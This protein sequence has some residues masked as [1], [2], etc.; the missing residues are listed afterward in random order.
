MDSESLGDRK[1]QPVS[2]TDGLR[3][4]PHVRKRSNASPRASYIGA[5]TLRLRWVKFRE[6]KSPSKECR[7]RD[8]L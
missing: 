2:G 1:S 4:E 6:P 3:S 8:A 7:R 5:T